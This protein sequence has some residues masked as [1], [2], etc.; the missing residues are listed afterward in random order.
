VCDPKLLDF[1]LPLV[2]FAVGLTVGLSGIGGAALMT[3]MLVILGVPPTYA[4]GSDLIFNAATKLLGSALHVKRKNVEF[5]VL[6]L[7]L[8]G[9]IPA[10][11]SCSLTL[12]YLKEAY[13]W[14]HLNTLL[15]AAIGLVLIAVSTI[16][17]V[18]LRSRENP[19]PPLQTRNRW[20]T[21][22]F[23]GFLIGFLIQLTS[24]GAGSILMPY[25]MKRIN[26]PRKMVGTS[27]LYGLLASSIAA[28]LHASLG[29]IQ[30]NI[31]LLMLAGS[32]PGITLGVKLNDK[33]APSS[34]RTVIVTL[35]L[36][37]GITVLLKTFLL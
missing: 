37:S 3:P 7:L 10:L 28:L 31:V 8:A 25:L 1:L 20:K 15:S 12:L 30:V 11:L 26:S 4:V 23:T 32:L 16:H 33:A 35:I 21:T 29:N 36:L 2:G 14:T 34:I 17:L 13:G 18:R 19:P 9:S 6:K 24:I 5:N 22:V 27:L